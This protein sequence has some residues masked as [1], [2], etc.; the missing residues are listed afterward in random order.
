MQKHLHHRMMPIRDQI[1]RDNKGNDLS[2]VLVLQGIKEILLNKD[3]DSQ[4][5][6]NKG[7]HHNN[8]RM[9]NRTDNHMVK[10]TVNLCMDNNQCTG[11]NQCTDSN[12]CTDKNLC[13]NNSKV[14]DD[15]EGEEEEWE[16]TECHL[17]L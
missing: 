3:M 11:N 15:L 6:D 13:I 12:Q 10:D 8:Q 5:M 4:R 7:I 1:D 9:D 16:V 14:A 2:P 17:P